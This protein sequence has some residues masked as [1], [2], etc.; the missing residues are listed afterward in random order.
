[1]QRPCHTL[2]QSKKKI[3]AEE[4]NTDLICVISAIELAQ[5][6]WTEFWARNRIFPVLIALNPT[7]FLVHC[8]VCLTQEYLHNKD[9]AEQ[10]SIV[11]AVSLGNTIRRLQ[12]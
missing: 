6:V 8:F 10:S 7:V 2:V 9:R 4:N 11:V 3:T 5:E 1:M 12:Q